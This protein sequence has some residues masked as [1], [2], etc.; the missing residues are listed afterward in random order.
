LSAELTKT[1]SFRLFFGYFA[2]WE[3]D[4][5]MI[6]MY[7]IS[8]LSNWYL[9]VYAY[10]ILFSPVYLHWWSQSNQRRWITNFEN[11]KENWGNIKLTWTNG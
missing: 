2:H 11:K 1:H 4:Y 9:Q 8:L 7:F 6:S 10:F 3:Y 5:F